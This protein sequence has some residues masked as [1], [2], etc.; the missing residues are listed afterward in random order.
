MASQTF[1]LGTLPILF[2][3]L[4]TTHSGLPIFAIEVRVVT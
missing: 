4:G 2:H 3:A 1:R